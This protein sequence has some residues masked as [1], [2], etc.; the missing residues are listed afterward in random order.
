MKGH[1]AI[2]AIETHRIGVQNTG[3][4]KC[5]CDAHSEARVRYRIRSNK[6]SSG[7]PWEDMRECCKIFKSKLI[8][9]LNNLEQI[10]MDIIAS[11]RTSKNCSKF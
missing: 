4:N 1:Y 3:W 11:H 8:W 2:A 9:C 7:R 6:P 5:V 10:R